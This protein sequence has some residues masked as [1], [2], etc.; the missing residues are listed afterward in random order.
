MNPIVIDAEPTMERR[1]EIM[2]LG[3]KGRDCLILA[4]QR[5]D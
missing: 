1:K 3:R 2:T 5:S 4:I